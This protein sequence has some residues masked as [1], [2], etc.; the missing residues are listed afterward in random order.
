MH[1][2]TT[3]LPR[4]VG[5]NPDGD[6]LGRWCYVDTRT[7]IRAPVASRSMVEGDWCARS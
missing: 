3:L 5:A 1:S 6:P 4:C 2:V 7:C